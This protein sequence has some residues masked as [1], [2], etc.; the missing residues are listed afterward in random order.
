MKWQKLM[1]ESL[2][3][4]IRDENIRVHQQEAELYEQLHPEIFN[5][6]EQKHL[7]RDLEIF[8]RPHRLD[9]GYALDVGCG[10]GNLTLKLPT[11]GYNVVALDVSEKMLLVLEPRITENISLTHIDIDVFLADCAKKFDLICFSSVLHH[12]PDYN[13][14]LAQ[15]VRQLNMDGFIY[16]THEPLPRGVKPKLQRQVST[17]SEYWY[18]LLLKLKGVP[19]GTIDYSISDYHAITGIEVRDICM[20]L[21]ALGLEIVKV[22]Q[23]CVERLGIIAWANNEIFRGWSD[24]FSF[25]AQKRTGT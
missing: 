15:A 16:V 12:L 22:R 23:Y 13:A 7:K 17:L 2:A 14:T 6:Y 24:T 1:D 21:Q 10:T 25:I 18:T 8:R 4:K 19:M 11:Y 5:W 9:H 20:Q 3:R